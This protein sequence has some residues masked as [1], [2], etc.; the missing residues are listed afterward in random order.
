MQL[1]KCENLDRDQDSLVATIIQIIGNFQKFSKIT[2]SSCKRKLFW[3]CMQVCCCADPH[4]YFSQSNF[5]NVKIVIATKT[6]QLQ[7]FSKNSQKVAR[8]AA[9]QL[10]EFVS[11]FIGN[12][13]LIYD[14]DKRLCLA[15]HFDRDQYCLIAIINK[16]VILKKFSKIGSIVGIVNYFEF[17]WKFIGYHILILTFVWAN[18]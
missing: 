5:L 8:L 14:F 17:L 15:D 1:F 12:R 6:V 16:F 10:S 2:E 18:F 3:I 4:A 9:L 7:R 13:C 11:L